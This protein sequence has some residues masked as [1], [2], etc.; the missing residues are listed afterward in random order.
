MSASE[1]AELT[2]PGSPVLRTMAMALAPRC[3]RSRAPGPEPAVWLAGAMSTGSPCCARAQNMPP[4][5][6]STR[7]VE[8]AQNGTSVSGPRGLDEPAR[9]SGA[10]GVLSEGPSPHGRTDGARMNRRGRKKRRPCTCHHGPSSCSP[11]ARR[12]SFTSASVARSSCSSLD[13]KTSRTVVTAH[14]RHW[15]HDGAWYAAQWQVNPSSP[16]PSQMTA[17][18]PPPNHSRQPARAAPERHRNRATDNSTRLHEAKRPFWAGGS[19]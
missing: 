14:L 17:P 8:L 16:T 11:L 4:R 10:Y 15:L 7:L 5:T 2:C 6:S 18:T 13:P 1:Y 3:S 12:N 9:Q 19:A